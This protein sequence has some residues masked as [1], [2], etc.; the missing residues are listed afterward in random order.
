MRCLLDT[1]AFLWYVTDDARLSK[2]A[3]ELVSHRAS[4]VH[5]SMA[6]LWEMAIKH[7]LGRLELSKPYR[8]F[9]QEQLRVNNFA[10]LPITFDHLVTIAGLPLHHRD[11]FDRLL[12]AQ[13]QTESLLLVSIDGHLDPYGIRRFW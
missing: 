13:A 7:K 5:V 12:V 2:A 4:E 10:L 1:H 3:L 6:S 8:D 11:P 9:M